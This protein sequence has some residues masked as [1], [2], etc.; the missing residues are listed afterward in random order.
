M[1]GFTAMGEGKIKLQTAKCS[2]RNFAEELPPH[3][4]CKW[5]QTKGLSLRNPE[6]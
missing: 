4:G 3:P 2:T 1:G 5:W 6:A